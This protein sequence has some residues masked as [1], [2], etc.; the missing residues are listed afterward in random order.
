MAAWHYASNTRTPSPATLLLQWLQRRLGLSEP[1]KPWHAASG[2]LPAFAGADGVT[3]SSGG[4]AVAAGSAAGGARHGAAPNSD[5]KQAGGRRRL[6]L[7][8][9]AAA[10]M[11]PKAK[12][13]YGI[14]FDQ[15]SHGDVTH[16]M[17]RN[18]LG[19]EMHALDDRDKAELGMLMWELEEKVGKLSPPGVVAT[20]AA[21]ASAA[22]ASATAASAHAAAAP[23]HVEAGAAGGAG[24]GVGASSAAGAAA[25]SHASRVTS[26]SPSVPEAVSAHLAAIKRTPGVESMCCYTE[27]VFWRHRPLL[28]Y[29]FVH[30]V[31]KYAYTPIVMQSGGFEHRSMAEL[32][33]WFRPASAAA[34]AP[35]D[36]GVD[37]AAKEAA[38]AAR[39]AT[40]ETMRTA[41]AEAG[42]AWRMK[43]T[44]SSS[45]ATSASATAGEGEAAHGGVEQILRIRDGVLSSVEAAVT[46]AATATSEVA[47]VAAS[48]A[49]A[50]AAAAAA[51]AEAIVFIHGV[52][53]GPAPYAPFLESVAGPETPVIAIEL[54]AAS[55][56]LFPHQPPVADRFAELVDDI[57]A[58]HNITR[59]VVMG[60]SLG[61]AYATMTAVRDGR[62]FPM[63]EDLSS[64][65]GPRIADQVEAV[66]AVVQ[67]IPA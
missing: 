41:E 57:L 43:A 10:F 53:F 17:S 4:V 16:W 52:G 32:N 47:S 7:T 27:P 36:E 30:F 6:S 21:A 15:L 35:R 23:R 58:S 28:Y 50:A 48:A 13:E 55:H 63:D 9:A 66:A 38:A 31:G 60:H 51:E 62:I 19:K 46:S 64:R 2:K 29:L 34:G 33:Y 26:P 65:W 54:E 67:Q 5:A 18:L 45:E 25:T 42:P 1:S 14:P 8:E 20:R 44:T 61:S 22:A 11:K 56:R 59:A 37:G 3:V 49:S 39:S 40:L 24:V 12:L